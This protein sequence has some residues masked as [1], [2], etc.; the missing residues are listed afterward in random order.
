MILKPKAAAQD[1]TE[2]SLPATRRAVFGDV[3]KLQFFKLALCGLI[4]LAAALPIFLVTMVEEIYRLSLT[5][6]VQQGELAQ[7]L[8]A[9][10]S[11]LSRSMSAV[12]QIPLLLLLAVALAG[13]GRIVKLLAWEEPV[14]FWS[15]LRRGLQ[16]NLRQMLVLAALTGIIRFACAYAA[17]QGFWLP[18]LLALLFLAPP[19]AYMAAGICVYDISLSQQ[20]RYALILYARRPLATLAACAVCAV[21]FLFQYL[22]NLSARMI[23]GLLDG[24]LIPV[25]MLGWFCFC[26]A[27]MDR[28]INPSRYPDLVGRGLAVRHAEDQ[29]SAI[30]EK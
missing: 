11:P 1:C 7:E 27:Q 28:F 14:L 26:F 8:A 2:A 17:G 18:G 22:P 25:V 9:L 21:P 10:Y 24:F 4:T 29:P 15:D 13:I 20:F 19:A 6:Q 16:Q 23:A 30:G 5:Q 3:L 12:L